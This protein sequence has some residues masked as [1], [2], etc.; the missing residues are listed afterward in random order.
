M[1]LHYFKIIKNFLF[2]CHSVSCLTSLLKFGQFRDIS[3]PGWYI[4]QRILGDIPGVGLHFFQIN[5]NC[6]YVCQSI[7]W[8]TYLM[9]LDKYGDISCSWW[10]IFLKF[11]GDI[12][13]MFVHFYKHLQI[14]F[15]SIS[16]LAGLPAYWIWVNIGISPVL[17]DISFRIFW[18]IFPVSF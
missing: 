14:S 7:R 9:K 13:E 5:A 10:D 2:V 1:F 12:P 11:Y 3:C 6:F 8:F 4:F 15:M 18:Q 17:D 16:L